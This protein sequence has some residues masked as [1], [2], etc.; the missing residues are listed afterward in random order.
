[1]QRARGVRNWRTIVRNMRTRRAGRSIAAALFGKTK[2][3]ILAALYAHP[4]RAFYLREL[5]R[6]AGTTPSSIQRELASLV[7]A[8]II[9]RSERGNLVYFQANAASPVFEELKGIVTKTFGV[10]D[11]LREALRPFEDR[12]DFAFIYG[13]VARG[14]AKAMSDIDLFLI[15]DVGLS[16][17]AVPLASAEDRLRRSVSPVIYST[18]EVVD[19]ARSGQHFLRAVLGRP[20]L[21]LIGTQDDLEK[22][23]QRKPRESRQGRVAAR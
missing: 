8:G 16:D 20:K 5:A 19:T 13:S 18:K 1:M 12:I 21:F 3:A 7:E 11:V 4:D 9:E 2:R 15:G 14:E 6:A 10:A 23:T 22:L 17:I